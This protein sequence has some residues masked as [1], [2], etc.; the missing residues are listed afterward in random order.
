MPRY[1]P[2][3][4]EELFCFI[5]TDDEAAFTELYNRYAG[6]LYLHARKRMVDRDAAMDLIH[7]IFASL[8]SN[9]HTIVLEGKCSS[10][11]YTALRYK[12][13]NFEIGRKRLSLWEEMPDEMDTRPDQP[14]PDQLVIAKDLENLI[15]AEAEKLP[16]KMR[17]VFLMSR[18]Q[19]LSHQ[20]I[21]D[22]LD[23]SPA[24]V[25]KQVNNA[26]KVLRPKF[27]HF[28]TIILSLGFL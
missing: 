12:I 8:W 22:E 3:T 16:K 25:K 18:R 19:Q 21:A 7:D 26:L 17:E 27:N 15:E 23:L 28:L 14:A 6:I 11:L 4:D 9:R 13:I 24:T 2:Y 10:Y 20:E 1:S 5:S